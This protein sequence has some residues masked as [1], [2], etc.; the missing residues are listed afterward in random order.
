LIV[1]TF[2]AL[3]RSFVLRVRC[4]MNATSRSPESP[5][6]CGGVSV[7]T[8]LEEKKGVSPLMK[9][10]LVSGSLWSLS[11]LRRGE[12]GRGGASPQWRACLETLCHDFLTEKL[13]QLRVL[14]GP[15]V[16]TRIEKATNTHT[17]VLL[18]VCVCV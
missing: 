9:E 5:S 10:P 6:A 2:A 3:Y 7:Y 14:R 18:C 4:P 17:F 1:D 13:F 8:G 16:P 11:L 15:N 12:R